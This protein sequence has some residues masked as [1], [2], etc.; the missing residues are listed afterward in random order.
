MQGKTNH[1]E[2]KCVVT[3]RR[4][5]ETDQSAVENDAVGREKPMATAPIL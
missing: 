5:K 3:V 2:L 4:T 1:W